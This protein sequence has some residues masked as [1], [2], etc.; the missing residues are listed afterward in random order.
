[1]DFNDI[2][3]EILIIEIV[4]GGK[5]THA[6]G[7][8]VVLFFFDDLGPFYIGHIPFPRFGPEAFGESFGHFLAIAVCAIITASP[9]DIDRVPPFAGIFIGVP[10]HPGLV[11]LFNKTITCG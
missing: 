10:V 7:F 6:V 9:L 5:E 11:R 1:V 8:G 4:H 3:E 2:S